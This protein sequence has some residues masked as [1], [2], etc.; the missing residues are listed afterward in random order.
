MGDELHNCVISAY[1]SPHYSCQPIE[2]PSFTGRAHRAK[3]LSKYPT[4][5]IFPLG[6]NYI[7]LY[8]LN[9]AENIPKIS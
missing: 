3:A 1:P 7:I 4:L 6:T 2:I 9:A 8:Q 5:N